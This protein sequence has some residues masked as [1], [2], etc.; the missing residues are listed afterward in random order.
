MIRGSICRKTIE[1]A[2]RGV[3]FTGGDVAAYTK[4]HETRGARPLDLPARGAGGRGNEPLITTWTCGVTY[5]ALERRLTAAITDNYLLL[6]GHENGV[7]TGVALDPRGNAGRGDVGG[8]LKHR[9]SLAVKQREKELAGRYRDNS[10]HRVVS[11]VC[12]QS[13]QDPVGRADGDTA[14]PLSCPRS[15][16]RYFPIRDRSRASG[17]HVPGAPFPLL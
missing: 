5:M 1:R 10:L 4:Q 9:F 12:V 15:V 3:L 14:T 7:L 6:R 11:C 8:K 13:T 2:A 17:S 16:G